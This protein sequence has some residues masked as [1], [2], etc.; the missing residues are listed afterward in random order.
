MLDSG[1]TIIISFCLGIGLAASAGFRVFLPL[2][3]LSLASYSGLELLEE[4]HWL[5]NLTS[6][7]IL[8]VATVVEILAYYIPWVDNMLDSIAIP[9]AG[10][11][12]TILMGVSFVGIE[13][14]IIHWV[15]AIIAGGGTA[16]TIKGSAAGG[17]L[18]STVSTGGVSNFLVSSIE[19]TASTVLSI[20]SLIFPLLGIILV[21]AVFYFIYKGWK[22]LFSRS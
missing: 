19:T 21:A 1:Y 20:I 11:A 15:I 9:I 3:I 18:A 7:I 6:L 14:E 10:I 16:A 22:Y 4:F 8:G 5:G 12:G 13:S 17:R 2:F